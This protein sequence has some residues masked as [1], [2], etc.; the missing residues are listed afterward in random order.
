MYLL[1]PFLPSPGTTPQSPTTFRML[2]PH[3]LSTFC[4]LF[5]SYL[6]HTGRASDALGQV[7]VTLWYPPLSC[8]YPFMGDLVLGGL[9]L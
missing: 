1:H 7:C 2:T 6:S 4:V 8:G 3:T 9:I 5:C